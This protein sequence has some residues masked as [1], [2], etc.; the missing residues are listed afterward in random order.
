MIKYQ[1]AIAVSNCILFNQ[2]AVTAAVYHYLKT[3]IT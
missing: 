1:F 2:A 3:A